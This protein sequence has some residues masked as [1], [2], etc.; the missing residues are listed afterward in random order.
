MPQSC[1]V[2]L[3]HYLATSELH[4]QLLFTSTPPV[5]PYS[6]KMH[7]IDKMLKMHIL[8]EADGTII[9]G[10]KTEQ[11]SVSLLVSPKDKNYMS[12]KVRV[13]ATITNRRPRNVVNWINVER[14]CVSGFAFVC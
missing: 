9:V 7:T 3:R 14:L 4:G 5:L 12:E 8:I 11:I 13:K 10:C 2:L 6:S 1:L